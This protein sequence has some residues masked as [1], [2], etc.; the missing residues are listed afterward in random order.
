MSDKRQTLLDQDLQEEPVNHIVDIDSEVTDGEG[1]P[2]V[3]S[4]KYEAYKKQLIQKMRDNQEVS[5]IIELSSK[6]KSRKRIRVQRG[7]AIAASFMVIF[8]AMGTVTVHTNALGIPLIKYLTGEYD[9][10]SSLQVAGLAPSDDAANK[11]ENNY[12]I[13]LQT[14]YIP[15]LP[16]EGYKEEERIVKQR[17]MMIYYENGNGQ[18]YWYRQST[19]SAWTGMDNELK[20]YQKGT[21][22]LGDVYMRTVQHQ[23]II[24][25]FYGG[26]VFSLSGNLEVEEFLE[27]AETIEVVHI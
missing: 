6:K 16:A 5:A 18:R 4:P 3:F 2:H 1:G 15:R 14:Y 11:E 19:Y 22:L 9:Q 10:Y 7:V 21:F 12:P 23:N 8:M 24:Y 17:K 13:E 20:D 26:Y 25:W 27:L